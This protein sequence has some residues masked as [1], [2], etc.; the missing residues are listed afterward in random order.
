MK[1]VRR[2]CLALLLLIVCAQLAGCSL[3]R[4]KPE[5]KPGPV[6]QATLIGMIEMVNPEQNYVVIRCDTPPAIQPGTELIA[7]SSLGTR[8]RLVL[9]PERKGYYLTADIKEGSPSVANL[10]LLPH[11]EEPPAPAPPLPAP[12]TPSTNDAST[13]GPASAVPS[14]P[15]P[16]LQ[17]QAPP[18][19]ATPP[20]APA[21]S[22]DD[23]EPPVGNP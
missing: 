8:S 16:A 5:K 9:S 12:E 15:L 19:G 14:T 20:A 11:S 7:L 4:K 17:P 18:P 13:P 22:L 3:L 6:G 1:P 21:A 2:H 10:V 23:L